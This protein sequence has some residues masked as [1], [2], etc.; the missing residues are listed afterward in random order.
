[1]VT[2]QWQG[3]LRSQMPRVLTLDYPGDPRVITR[4]GKCGKGRW[5]RPLESCRTRNS[6]EPSGFAPWRTGPKPRTA[7]SHCHWRRQDFTLLTL[8]KKVKLGRC[9]WFWKTGVW[10]AVICYHSTV[11][12]RFTLRWDGDCHSPSETPL[13]KPKLKKLIWKWNPDS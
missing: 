11:G 2:N 9:L 13:K 10:S 4:T 5:G 12:G 3:A 6:A 8:L 1:M 7:G